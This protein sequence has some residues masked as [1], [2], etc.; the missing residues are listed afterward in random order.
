M[1][2]QQIEAI[3]REY[4][5]TIPHLSLATV[6]SSQPWV[7]EVHFAA[8]DELNLYFVSKGSTRHA[9]EIAG[10]PHVAGNIVRQHGLAEAPQGIYFEGEA[11]MLVAPT[12]AEAERYAMALGGDTQKVLERLSDQQHHMYR[13]AVRNWA[14]FGNFEGTGN[15]KYG[16]AWREDKQ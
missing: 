6:S 16:L 10:N 14:V 11:A 3:I 15:A 7:C 1:T 13:I 8:D 5:T 12:Q 4:I 2:D 9:Q